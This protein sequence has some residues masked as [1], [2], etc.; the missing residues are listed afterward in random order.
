MLIKNQQLK[1]AEAFEIRT[2]ISQKS[3][4][5][6]AKIFETA[7][8]EEKGMS[9]LYGYVY[10]LVDD[11]AKTPGIGLSLDITYPAVSDLMASL[12]Y[13]FMIGM[14]SGYSVAK[15]IEIAEKTVA[16]FLYFLAAN[17]HNVKINVGPDA[18]SKGWT[19]L[20][21]T[22]SAV[23]NKIDLLNSISGKI[24]FKDKT[25][26]IKVED[27]LNAYK[28]LTGVDLKEY[29]IENATINLP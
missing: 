26:E 27:V 1:Y 3:V 28:T 23:M 24:S 21:I 7:T 17:E 4:S 16:A 2:L 5:E 8:W 11:I 22:A 6:S 19:G 13:E 20:K 18:T 15:N 29:G 12:G 25:L 14:N 9:V 10:S